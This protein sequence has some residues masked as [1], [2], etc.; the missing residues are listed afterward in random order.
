MKKISHDIKNMAIALCLAILY[1][2]APITYADNLSNNYKA[3]H[4]VNDYAN[5]LTPEQ[6]QNINTDLSS[7]DKK[8]SNQIVIATFNSLNG[9]SLEDFSIKLANKWK[10]GTK[11]NNNGVLLLII[12]NDRKMRIEVGR[13][14]EG[15]LTDGLSGD[16]I[17][18]KILPEF[19]QQNYYLG[20][21]KGVY[22]IEQAT[23]GEYK[24][25]Q[26][27]NLQ[28]K[29]Q[30]ILPILFSIFIVI[31]IVTVSRSYFKK[32]RFTISSLKK[33][34]GY[35]ASF[36]CNFLINMFLDTLVNT[37]IGGRSSGGGFGG[38]GSFG[39]GFGGGG[40]GF[41]GGGASGGW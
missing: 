17:R 1:L 25:D 39:G 41:G 13:G 19:K 28:N 26:Y 33:K 35:F 16:I 6:R 30:N 34:R 8:T 22:S 23:K 10:I 27:E 24:P 29:L 31:F 15:A 36:A 32:S 11:Q 3:D 7:F 20:I 14:L 40:G 12:K 2:F 37:L 4:Y 38:G 18:N 5:M 21:K 9:K